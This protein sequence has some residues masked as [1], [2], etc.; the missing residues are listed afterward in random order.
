MVAISWQNADGLGIQLGTNE[1]IQR[2]AGEY[3]TFGVNRVSEVVVTGSTLTS[4]AVIQDNNTEIP[5]NAYIEAV[6][7]ET[8]TAATGS[9]ATL[10]FG[11]IRTD[12]TTELDYNGFIAAFALST[13]SA[14]GYRATLVTGSTGVGA[15]VGTVLSNPGFLTV[16]YNTAAITAGVVR[17]R[18]F[19]RGT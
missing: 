2:T 9:G 8:T 13:W 4:S 6:E 18:V 14:A 11:L 12:R 16:N 1:A 10:D 15:L 17:L 5:K 19:W 7:I 3:K